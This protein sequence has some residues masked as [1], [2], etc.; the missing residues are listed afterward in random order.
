ML[1][2]LPRR[3]RRA[4]RLHP[5]HL[6][7]QPLHRPVKPGMRLPTGQQRLHLPL[8]RAPQLVRHRTPLSHL[9]CRSPPRRTPK[10]A[11]PLL[12]V[13]PLPASFDDFLGNAP[14]VE[15]LRMSVAAG[16]L[17]H[18]LI[19]AGPAGSGK[20][21][22]A[23]LL[24]LALQCE[25]QPR[26][27]WSNGQSLAAFCGVCR[28]CTRIAEAADLQAAVAAA[29]TARDDL[30]E[31]D[32]K[33]TRVLVQP[34]PDVLILPPDPTP[35][36]HQARPGPHPHPARPLPPLRSPPQSLHPHLRRHHERGRQLP[37]S[38]SSKNPHP[39]STSSCS[40]KTPANS[41]QPSAPA[42]P[43]S[44][45]A[46]SPLA[47]LDLLLS[48]RRPELP[49]AQREL[50]ARL[51]QGAAG[52]ALA[53]NLPDFLAARNDALLLLRQA[54]SEPDHTALFRTTETYRAG[55]EG[56]EKTLALLR[57]LALLL[58]DLLLLSAGTPELLRNTD[59]RPEL[60]TLANTLPFPW[61]EAAVRAL[62][63]VHAGLRRNLLR[64]L[65][66]DALAADLQA[67]ALP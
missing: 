41:S 46:P 34:H 23:L 8:Y 4:L 50:I 24:T 15:Q 6:R 7:R 17:P 43:P 11:L 55:A 60:S 25:R 33:D 42:A 1:Q 21:T 66:L 26:D 12:P 13:P 53:F 3:V 48:S 5:A 27:L 59:L 47:E 31:T 63:Q 38:K 57:A 67:A 39:P 36:P 30:R 9:G 37:S 64:S 19:L 16:R 54:A 18:A 40:P 44:A 35:A 22:L 29:V 49:L 45:S 14:A 52:R 58:E 56:Q 28:N 51:A 2:Q 10:P 32:K 20:Y 61:I 65:S 62:D